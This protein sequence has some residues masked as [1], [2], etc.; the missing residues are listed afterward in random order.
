LFD[1][2]SNTLMESEPVF[3]ARCAA[4]GLNAATIQALQ[5]SDI[6]TMA[7]LAFVSG[8]Q[9]GSTDDKEF[10]EIMKTVLSVDPVPVGTLSA[11][12][13][14]WFEANAM[15]I[16]EVKSRY[17]KTEEGSSTM[18]KLPLPEREH[19]RAAQQRML[20]GVLIE[21]NL[22]PAHCLVDLALAI[23]EDDI[24]RW[25]EP[26]LCIS[27]EQEIKGLKRENIIRADAAGVLK[28][29][30]KDTVPGADLSTEYRLRLAL[31]RRSLAMDQMS[32]LTY[33]KSEQYHNMLFD[34]MMRAVPSSHR[35]IGVG[36]ILEADKHI[37]SRV[38]EYCRNG[39][40]VDASGVY[41]IETA[42]DKA[43]LDP[44]TV[45]LL[46]PLP[47]GASYSSTKSPAHDDRPTPYHDYS[48]G[49]DFGK[50]R[51]GRGKGKKGKGKNQYNNN[52]NGPFLPK[53][54]QGSAVSKSGKRICFGFNL[55]SCSSTNCQKGQHICCK[56]F[57]QHSF[58]ECPSKN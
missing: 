7:K 41:P 57:G 39:V 33:V 6:T 36:Q 54:L 19:R 11:L 46:Q 14:L 21:G 32:L 22:E 50:G 20:Q 8:V 55:G 5:A 3:N 12:R 10:V 15:A 2:M 35:P 45:S 48:K 56:C 25:I 13:R 4:V 29:V 16:N 27:R 24:V 1:R 42:L 18:K 38:A 34:L 37:W 53:G 51:K 58:Q 49:S 28:S 26:A 52:S 40:Q 47:A 23:K 31:Q 9:P 43:L 17:E 44:I 30:N